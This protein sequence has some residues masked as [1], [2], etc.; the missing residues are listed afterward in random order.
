MYLARKKLSFINWF[1]GIT[2]V[3]IPAD[4]LL[5]FACG[6]FLKYS[7]YCGL[8]N[9]TVVNTEHSKPYT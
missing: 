9:R 6:V 1:V 3:T 2:M 5:V 7:Y 8:H 4:E